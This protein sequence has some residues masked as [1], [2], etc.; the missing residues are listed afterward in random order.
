MIPHLFYI[1]FFVILIPYLFFRIF[2]IEDNGLKD[3]IR[4]WILG[5]YLWVIV[6]LLFEKEYS[7]FINFKQLSFNKFVLIY[8]DLFTY[9]IGSI[10][11]SFF[12]LWIITNLIDALN[13]RFKTYDSYVKEKSEYDFVLINLTNVIIATLT[14]IYLLMPINN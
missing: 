2:K 3:F 5:T 12:I 8:K 7:Y 1:L 11:I 6:V 10:V 14:I 9:H 13:W 4:L